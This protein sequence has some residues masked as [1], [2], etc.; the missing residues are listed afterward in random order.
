[1][2]NIPPEFCRLSV[3]NSNVYRFNSQSKSLLFY[4]ENGN[5]KEK[6]IINNP[7]ANILSRAWDGSLIVLN[8]NLIMSSCACNK[9]IKFSRKLT[10]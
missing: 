4:D 5:F 6:I 10:N 1:M 9:L 7:V 3:I 2:D 8:G